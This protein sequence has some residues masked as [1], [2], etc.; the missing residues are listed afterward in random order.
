[1]EVELLFGMLQGDKPTRM[2]LVYSAEVAKIGSLVS[3]CGSEPEN[4]NGAEI[5]HRAKNK[6]AVPA[7][8]KS[9]QQFT[10]LHETRDPATRLGN[11]LIKSVSSMKLVV[12]WMRSTVHEIWV[13][14][15]VQIMS[16]HLRPSEE[17]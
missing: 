12:I 15:Q 6:R 17:N 11:S 7:T 14:L 1:V 5:L 2:L 10:C 13:R 8:R 9:T 16:A 4:K 3:I